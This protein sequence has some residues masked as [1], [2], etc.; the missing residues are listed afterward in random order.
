ME[1]LRELK[2][3]IYK[4]IHCKACRF[5][6]SGEPDR[7]GI[8]AHTGTEGSANSF[9]ITL[10]SG[11]LKLQPTAVGDVKLFDSSA[12]GENRN[13]K[14]YGYITADTSAKYIQHQVSDTSDRYEITREDAYVLGM[15]IG[16]PL[17]ILDTASQ[18]KLSHDGSNFTTLATQS[19]GDLTID[20]NKTSYVLD[21]GDGL[22]TTT[23][24]VTGYLR[25]SAG[26]TTVAPL[27]IA[28]GT[29]LTT[30]E[31]GAV[32]FHDDKFWITNV[33]TRRVIDRTSC[34]ETS[35]T[36][37][38]DTTTETAIY[39]CPIPANS[40]KVGNH[41]HIECSGII[42]N[43]TAADDITINVYF[44]TDLINTFN[45]AILNVTN[46]NWHAALNVTVRTIGGSGTIASHGHVEIDGSEDTANEL[47]T[48]DTTGANDITVK[49]IWDNQKIGNTI[50]SYQ[51]AAHWSN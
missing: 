24:T 33:D 46:A 49:V 8:G 11:D 43:A 50:S 26:T 45:P 19:D 35:T 29:A 36:T 12:S 44:G 40:L 10:G 20:S 16:M 7:E 34:V 32:E 31:T 42:S 38:A 21:L 30:P 51:G 41:L 28:T 6:Y 23:G 4:C 2:G 14:Q 13:L 18:L 22:V 5:S 27:K 39:T 47:D 3:D 25:A 17:E 1:R 9:D 37:V 15:T 48:I